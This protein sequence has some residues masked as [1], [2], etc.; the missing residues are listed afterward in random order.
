MNINEDASK[1]VAH[2]A[3]EVKEAVGHAK[4]AVAHAAESEIAQ[5][6][7]AGLESAVTESKSALGTLK[8]K[9]IDLA[10]TVSHK[11]LDG[12]GKIG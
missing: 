1:V 3:E 11:D 6:A 12:D 10:E 5:K 4:D 2:V 9:A 7:K 8:E